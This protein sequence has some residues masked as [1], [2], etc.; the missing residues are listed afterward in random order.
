MKLVRWLADRLVPLLTPYQSPA[1]RIGYSIQTTPQDCVDMLNSALAAD[2]DAVKK[3]FKHRVYCN[4][5]LGEH[6]TIQVKSHDDGKCSVSILGF[7]NGLFGIDADGW[8][9]IAGIF[10]LVCADDARHELPDD[11]TYGDDCPHCGDEITTGDVQEF[12]V[13]KERL[14]RPGVDDEAFAKISK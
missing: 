3:L 12:K 6:P 13:L 10:G 7:L 14:R 2:P 9:C 11:A 1:A 8:G 4:D 5:E